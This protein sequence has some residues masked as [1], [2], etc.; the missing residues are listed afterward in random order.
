[1][2]ETINVTVANDVV[3]PSSLLKVMSTI[4]CLSIASDFRKPVEL[5]YP[6]IAQRYLSVIKRPIDLGT[7]LLDC[8]NGTA[9]ASYIREGL[10]LVFAN[11]LSFNVGSPM[12]EAISRHLESYASGLF[13]EAT[14]LP[15]YSKL[16][17]FDFPTELIKKRSLRLLSVKNVPLR[18]L[19]VKD[20]QDTLNSLE[21]EIPSD[22][23]NALNNT[24]TILHG[25]LS[26]SNHVSDN[27]DVPFLTLEMIFKPILEAAVTT[28]EA[29]S[30]HDIENK[31]DILP[32]LVILVGIPIQNPS[33]I[34]NTS[35]STETA[36]NSDRKESDLSVNAESSLDNPSDTWTPQ[37]QVKP[38]TISLPQME[39]ENED[40]PTHHEYWTPQPEEVLMPLIPSTLPYLRYK[41]VCIYSYI[42]IMYIY[43]HL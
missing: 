24:N 19:E 26:E 28:T 1:M 43:I 34:T 39:E 22:L 16:E 25:H 40:K 7:L 5:L 8:M 11:S 37:I 21:S 35:I 20:I 3:D 41:Y 32:A 12:M 38:T 14:K 33:K 27:L 42:S 29:Y 30:G 15:F 2:S 31:S 18:A 10:R 9:T 17:H 36:K 4:Y 23:R 13:E 6:N